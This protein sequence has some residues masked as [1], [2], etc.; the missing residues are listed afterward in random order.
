MAAALTADEEAFYEDFTTQ[1]FSVDGVLKVSEEER[2]KALALARQADKNAALK[3]QAAFGTTD[4]RD[5]LKLVTVPTLVIHGGADA[6]V[7]F[8]GSGRRTHEAIPG[9][10]VHVIAGA[11]HGVNVSDAEEFNRVVLAFLA[12]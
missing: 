1:F 6:I 10:E 3:C 2:Q 11:P 4:F 8:E 7:P 5:D 12:K 9:S